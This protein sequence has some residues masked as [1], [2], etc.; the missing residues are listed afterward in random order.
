MEKVTYLKPLPI[1]FGRIVSDV[2]IGCST[3]V[4]NTLQC[5]R[6]YRNQASTTTLQRQLLLWTSFPLYVNHSHTSFVFLSATCQDTLSIRTLPVGMNSRCIPLG[7]LSVPPFWTASGWQWTP[8][9]TPWPCGS[10]RLCAGPGAPRSRSRPS[11]G[12]RRTTLWHG[13]SLGVWRR[14][15]DWATASHTRYTADAP[16]GTR[17]SVGVWEPCEP[18]APLDKKT[19]RWGILGRWNSWQ[20]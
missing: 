20:I 7:S 8:A 13:G 6:R 1:Q 5:Y 14:P 10:R 19:L 9:G 18:A 3:V 11:S 16:G 12:G 4:I 2:F 15:E 17:P